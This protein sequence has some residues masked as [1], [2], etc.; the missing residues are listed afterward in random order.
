VSIQTVLEAALQSLVA[1][2]PTPTADWDV[3]PQA[4]PGLQEPTNLFLGWLKWGG[5]LGG[6]VGLMVTGIMMTIGRRGRSNMAVEGAVGVPWII[7]G[8]SVISVS[9]GVVLTILGT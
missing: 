7:A 1:P 9:G 4:P 3:P 5:Y 8:L 6:F 2:A